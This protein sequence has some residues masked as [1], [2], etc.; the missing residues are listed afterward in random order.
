MNATNQGLD[1]VEKTSALVLGPTRKRVLQ[2][3]ATAKK[4]I[5]KN[6]KN[7]AIVAQELSTQCKP[8][9][10]LFEL[11]H[12]KDS[13]HK[14]E[15]FDE[16]ADTMIDC[17]V[18]YQKLTED[19]NAFIEILQ[20]SLF[21]ATAMDIRARVQ[22]NIE[23]GENNVSFE[24]L[25][26]I[27]E[28]LKKIQVSP[29]SCFTKFAQMKTVM[30]PMLLKIAETE[31][32][33]SKTVETLSDTFAIVLRGIAID[34]NDEALKTHVPSS[35][36]VALDA[37]QLA[38]NL[39]KDPELTAKLVADSILLKRNMSVHLYNQSSQSSSGCMLFFVL[40]TVG[41]AA[42]TAFAFAR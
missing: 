3:I 42:G 21:F 35:F 2:H 18:A 39:V 28:L 36:T 41:L 31:G 27:F 8:L 11:F 13:F 33:D 15:L 4:G 16:V 32:A 37:I 10:T 40:L 17:A 6:P 22:R 30:M 14:T 9:Q 1:D 20:K 34:A 12:G 19:N 25:E 26:P 24:R 29:Q 38:Q 5:E 23:I 7:G